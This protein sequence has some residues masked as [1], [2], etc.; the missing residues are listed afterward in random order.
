MAA[1]KRLGTTAFM[2]EA[3]LRRELA[4]TRRRGNDPRVK[5]RVADIETMLADR[6]AKKP[7]NRMARALADSVAANGAGDRTALA[8]AKDEGVAAQEALKNDIANGVPFPTEAEVEAAAK[9][10]PENLRK[11]FVVARDALGLG[12]RAL[13]R[14]HEV[15]HV[16]HQHAHD[17]ADFHLVAKALFYLAYRRFASP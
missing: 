10:L 4:E 5:Q 13:L 16:S 17:V 9:R 6:E 2:D 12:Q 7:V 8:H 14:R 15:G 1:A 11:A 3:S